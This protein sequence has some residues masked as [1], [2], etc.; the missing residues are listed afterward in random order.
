MTKT[1]IVSIKVFRK[2][3]QGLTRAFTKVQHKVIIIVKEQ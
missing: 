3:R 1:K 2:D